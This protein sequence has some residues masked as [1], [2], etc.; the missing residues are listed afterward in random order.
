MVKKKHKDEISVPVP[1]KRIDVQRDEL[2]G[3]GG[4]YVFDPETGKRIRVSGPV[5]SVQAVAEPESND[6]EV[7]ND[8][9][10]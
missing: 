8:E 9:I 7:L 4:S 5:L 3:V 10:Q 1:E 6:P 2:R